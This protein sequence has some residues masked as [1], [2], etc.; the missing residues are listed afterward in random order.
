MLENHKEEDR[1][2]DAHVP[3]IRRNPIMTDADMAMKIEA[4]RLLT[5]KAAVL[6]DEGKRFSK[7]NYLSFLCQPQDPSLYN[8]EQLKLKF[9]SVK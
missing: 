7:V 3:G 9:I 4:S 8:T 1:P 6:K 5:Y 2:F